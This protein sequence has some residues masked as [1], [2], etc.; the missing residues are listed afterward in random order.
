MN[1][2]YT[3]LLSVSKRYLT[4]KEVARLLEL[5]P[6]SRSVILSRLVKRNVLRRLRRN[7]YE[8]VFKPSEILEA[9]S[10]VYQPSYLSF[11]YCLGKLGLLNQIAYEIEFATPKKT[12]R[13]ELRNRAVI[14]RQIAKKLFFG[15]DLKDNIFIAQ[16]EKA[17]LDTLYIKSKGLTGLNENELNLNGLSKAKFLKMSKRFPISVQKEAKRIV[18]SCKQQATG[19]KP[20]S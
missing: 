16:P 13:V 19:Y 3:K 9:A 14:F 5:K 11:T 1:D 12:K 17:L 15:Y 6:K 18:S 8:V 4:S 7:L 10:S 2:V 20:E